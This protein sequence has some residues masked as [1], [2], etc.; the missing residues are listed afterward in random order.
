MLRQFAQ[1]ALLCIA[2][3]SVYS[4]TDP[5]YRLNT[6]ITP[7]AY[8][9]LITPYFDTGDDKAFTF[10]GEVQITFTTASSINTIKLHSEDLKYTASNIT[11]TNGVNT[12]NL[13][14]T[15]ALEFEE[16]YSFA[17]INLASDLSSGVEYIL[18]I[19]YTGPIRTDLAGFYRNYYI[20]KGVKKWLGATQFESTSARKA[21]PC[22]DEP[23]YKAVFT[24]TID[25]PA[26]YKPSLANTKL[27]GTLQLS[28]GFV[29]ETFYP[30]PKMSTY[31]L[32]FLVSEFEAEHYSVNGTKELGV[33][34]RPE[35]KNQ[36]EYAFDFA[37]RVVQALGNYFGIDYY[38]TN[39]NLKLDH[40]ALLD[41]KAGAMENW[42]LVTYRESLLLFIPEES[43]PYY[44]YRVAQIIAHETTH[45]WFGNLVTC[46]WWSN[47]WL[48]E[49]F[50]NYFQD[51]ITALIEPDVAADDQLIIGS[52]YTALDAD[53]KPDSPPITNNNVNS[54]DEISGHFGSISY[55]K[56]GSVIRMIHHLIGDNAFK[57][58]LNSYLIANSFQPGYPERLYTALSQGVNVYNSLASYPGHD[59]TDIMSSWISRSG[60]PLVH[61]EVNH[62][63]SSIVLTQK[64]FYIHSTDKS[65]EIYKIPITLSLETAFDFTNTK[66]AF[67]MANKTYVLPVRE[68]KENHSWPILNIQESGLYRVNYDS[69]TWHHISDHLKSSRREEIHY[70]NRAK[71]VNDLFA[72]LFADEEKFD[73]LHDVL[74]F[75]EDETDHAVWFAAIRG[76]KKLRSHY[77]GT[78]TLPIID[79]FILHLMESSVTRLGLEVKSTDDIKTRRNRM[80]VLDLACKIGYQGCIDGA[81]TLYNDFKNNGKWIDP[82]LREVVYCTGLRYGNGEDYDFL[83]NRMFTT[84]VANEAR[85]IGDILG[86]T[87]DETKLNSFLVSM[88]VENSPI[89]IQ[90]L[91]VPLSGVLSN[92]SNVHVVIDSLQNNVSLWK[93]IYVSL[94]SVLSSVASALRSDDE[95][96][97][98]ENWLSTCTECGE[99]AVTSARSS[100]AKTKVMTQWAKD[101]RSD[102]W[103]S[104]RGSASI[105]SVSL[106]MLLAGY[107]LTYK[108]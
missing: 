4:E 19:V 57:S 12:I 63:D 91:T 5:K 25:R 105:T 28:N 108:F 45:M 71:I 107:I 97:K 70:L 61:V 68:I 50:A 73:L 32:A 76:F 72:F 77:L 6:T 18:K 106:L 30:T 99:S 96:N 29:R 15:N 103:T 17:H 38:S 84:N 93:S 64:R 33:F 10:D 13:A 48:N 52:V 62:A 94:D 102:I 42:G 27:Q 95:I 46:H 2:V 14:E 54:P 51:Y 87:S 16:K 53:D 79:D 82:S 101:H 66:P 67:I 23:E 34:T 3:Q 35:A 49:G 36:T 80:Q 20:E 26:N 59:I 39:S 44:K 11:L 92:Y 90:D 7:S 83:W 81:L 37:V 8:T 86:C 75:L 31:L 98:F 1:L 65:D 69:H 24:L 41:F 89:K 21:F 88:L 9:I 55:Q 40:I 60:Y 43:T 100:L 58:G 104:L 78:D 22:F 74:H 56:A 85:L 47:T